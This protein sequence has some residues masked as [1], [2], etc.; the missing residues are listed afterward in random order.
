MCPRPLR[1]HLI[2]AMPCHVISHRRFHFLL[3]DVLEG[4]DFLQARTMVPLKPLLEYSVI[5]P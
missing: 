3:A 5:I 4:G 2:P 1:Y